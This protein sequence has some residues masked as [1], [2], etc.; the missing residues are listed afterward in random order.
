MCK[1]CGESIDHLF[2]HC[3]VG[4][5][6]DHLF[7]HC[8]VATKF[9][10]A[11]FQLLSVAWVLPQRVSELLVSWRRQL[12]NR[13]ALKIWRLPPLCLKWCLWR[14][15]SAKSFEDRENGLLEIRKMMLQSLYT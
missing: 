1:K 9:C 13:N 15:R 10:S 5:S 7:L 8:E 11:L 6:I 12:R 4:E 2:L 3:E 14:E